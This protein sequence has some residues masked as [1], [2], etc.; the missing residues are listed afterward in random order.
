MLRLIDETQV[1]LQA[2]ILGNGKDHCPTLGYAFL[3]EATL[4]T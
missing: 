3:L 4:I 1:C 2:A